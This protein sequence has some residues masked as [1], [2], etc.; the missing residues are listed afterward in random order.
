VVEWKV[1][2]SR[3]ELRIADDGRGFDMGLPV[4]GHFGLENMR[5][6]ASDIGAEF[7]LRSQPGEGTEVK[8]TLEMAKP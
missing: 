7:R 3:A 8:V 1:N 2:A 5:S 4:P 6:R